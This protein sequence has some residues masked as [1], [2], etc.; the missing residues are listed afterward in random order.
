M[1]STRGP[2]QPHGPIGDAGS[3]TLDRTVT[4]LHE[5]ERIMASTLGDNDARRRIQTSL[6]VSPRHARRYMRAVRRLWA[7][8]AG[9]EREQV[10]AELLANYQSL[11]ARALAKDDLGVA[12]RILWRLVLLHGVAAPVPAANYASASD[13]EVIAKAK[14]A[15]QVLERARLRSSATP[16]LVVSPARP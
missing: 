3:V 7:L 16:Y 13:E 11:Y 1:S 9:K 10:R 8:E 2:G 15:I 4:R 14:E 6:R 5:A 12:D